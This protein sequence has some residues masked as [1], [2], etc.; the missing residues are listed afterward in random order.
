MF[1]INEKFFNYEVKL[2]KEQDEVINR[3]INKFLSKMSFEEQSVSYYKNK[4][5]AENINIIK[6]DIFLGKKAEYIVAIGLHK[7]YGIPF[8]EPDIKIR[9]GKYKGWEEDLRIENV[10]IHVK[11][12]NSHTYKYCKDYSWTFQYNNNNGKDGRDKI[13]NKKEDSLCCFVFL[14]N[15]DSDT[16]II[17]AMLPWSFV[18]NKLK[19]PKKKSLVGI[20]KCIYYRDIRPEKERSEKR[21][22]PSSY[23]GGWITAA[24]YIVELLCVLMTKRNKKQLKDNFWQEDPWNKFYKRQVPLANELLK[25][26]DIDAITRTLKDKRCYNIRSLGANWLIDPILKEK[27]RELDLIKE[28]NK[29]NTQDTQEK[30]PTNLK[31]RAVRSNKKSLF[32]TLKDL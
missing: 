2:T 25:E 10:N 19:D 7:K 28:Q 15:K 12:C 8:V 9:E 18:V 22:F 14:E 32:T 27:Q 6:E 16:G 23:N 31:P 13:F 29:Q 24:Q 3:K 4:R 5:N 1:D 21:K 30:T 11:S 26:Y 20:K 17:K